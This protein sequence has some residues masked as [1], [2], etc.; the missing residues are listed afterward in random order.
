M[1]SAT[2]HRNELYP[3][4]FLQRPPRWTNHLACRMSPLCG[5]LFP[6]WPSWNARSCG[7]SQQAPARALIIAEPSADAVKTV[8]KIS[9]K[10]AWVSGDLSLAVPD[11]L[12][13]LEPLE[14][15]VP[16]IEWLIVTCPAMRG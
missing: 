5:G 7:V 12:A 16:N 4:T 2:G 8:P 9:A 15:R 1:K 13:N 6:A 11:R 10:A 14:L 3:A